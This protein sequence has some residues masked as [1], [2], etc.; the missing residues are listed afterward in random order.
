MRSTVDVFASIRRDARV[1]GLSVREL[2]RRHEVHH[3]TVRAALAS[4][5]PPPR[6][7]QVRVA[8]R[9]APFREAIDEMLRVDLDAPAE[10]TSHGNPG[11]GEAG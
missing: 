4:A 5:E 9:L 6:K 11:S 7:V 10:A 3:R 2:A 1:E 8:P